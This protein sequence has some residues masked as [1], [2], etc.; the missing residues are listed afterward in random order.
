MNKLRNINF[1]N[2]FY[3]KVKL[4]DA[5]TRDEDAIRKIFNGFMKLIY[6][7]GNITNEEIGYIMDFAIYYRNLVIKQIYNIYGTEKYN[8]KVSYEI[9]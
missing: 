9:M 5:S 6:P 1:D 3:S 7:H 2:L 8:R 4:I